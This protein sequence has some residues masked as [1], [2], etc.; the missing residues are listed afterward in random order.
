MTSPIGKVIKS[1]EL[2]GLIG[3]GGFGAV[4][5]AR[6]AVVEREVAIKIIWPAFANH[7]NFI[8][9]FEAEAQIVAGLEHPYI[10]PLY[11]Y[12]R[13]PDGAYIVMRLLRGGHLRQ[14]I[15]ETA[16][17]TLPDILRVV[18]Q[19]AAALA[20]AH[21]Y[22]VVHRDI[23]PENILLDEDKNTY[24]ADFGI[25]QIISNATAD[26]DVMASMGSP[27]YA[28]PEQIAGGITS[29][30]SD[31]YSLGII[32]YEMLCSEH[33]FPY[34]DELS[35]T[36][37]VQLR[38]TEPV[39]S[40]L[41]Q[42]PDL[43]PAVNNVIQRATALDARKRYP[44]ALSFYQ[45]LQQAFS[46]HRRTHSTMAPIISDDDILPN[47]YKGLRAFQET[48]AQNFF[49]REALV[50]RM[51]NR[52]KESHADYHRFLTV[53]GPSGSGKSSVV[54]AG[55]LPAMRQG[56]MENSEN[57]FYDDFVPGP[58]PFRELENT[59]ISLATDPP[60]NLL[61]QLRDDPTALSRIIPRLLP[62]P[63]SELFLV[64]DQFEEIFTLGEQEE[65]VNRF[66]D[67]LYYAVTAPDSR[68]RL[69][70]TIRADFYDRPL[71]Q[72]RLS[73]M[74]R[75]RT[76]VVVPLS[77][78][79]L[80]KVIV[81]PA[82]RAGVRIDSGLVAAIIAEIKEQPGALPLLQY[83]LS[84]LFEHRRDNVIT[85]E[86]YRDL[87]G[88]RGSLARRADQLYKEM[89]DDERE[90]V[91]QLFLRLITLGEGTE[92]TRRRAL[93][94][95]ITTLRDNDPS[96]DDTAIMRRVVDKLGAVRLITFD[97]DPVTRS[98]TVEV[99][100]EAI[101]R[102]WQR[103]RDWLDESRNDVRM[104]RTLSGLANE[105]HEAQQDVSFLMRGIR[106]DS[107]QKWAQETRLALTDQEKAYLLNS[108]EER[109][110]RIEEEKRR[111]Q[112][113][114]QL[115][116]QAL[117]RLRYLVAVLAVAMLGALLLSGFA[118]NESNRASESARQAEVALETS[119]ASALI[120]SSLALEA[121]ARR[122][123]SEKDGDLAVVLA[124]Q[125]N[126]IDNPPQQ[127]VT[128]LSEVALSRGTR[129]RIVAHEA[130]V[131]AVDISPDGT[132][133]VSTSTDATVK[134]RDMA[135]GELLHSMSGHGGDVEA[136]AFSPDGQTVLSAA[137]DFL[138][139]LWDANTGE[140][141][142]RFIGHSLPVRSVSFHPDGTQAVTAASDSLLILWDVNTGEEIRRYAGHDGSV[143]VA[144]FS[145][146]GR[147]ILSGARDGGLFLWDAESGTVLHRMIGH[148]TTVTDVTFSPD[149]QRAVSGSGDGKIL[150]WDTATG[151]LIR[152]FVGI[153]D[154]VRSVL[155][156]PDGDLVYSSDINGSIHVWDTLSGLEIDRLEGHSDTVMNLAISQDGRV[157]ASGSKD[158]TIRLWNI[159]NPAVFQTF[160][161]HDNRV[162]KLILTGSETLYSGSA[163]GSLRQWN[164]ADN[165][166]R[167][168]FQSEDSPV[169]S[170]SINPERT[171]IALGTRGGIFRIIDLATGADMVIQE[172]HDESVLALAYLSD[173]RLL[174]A[175]ESGNIFL[176]NAD[177]TEII[178][179]FEG[180]DNAIYSIAVHP[181]E[182]L[183]ASGGRDNQAI[184]WDIETGEPLHVL[185]NHTSSI[186]TVA[187]S[188]DGSLLATGSRDTLVILWDVATGAEVSPLFEDNGVVWSVAF[189]HNGDELLVG[190]GDGE[191][192]LWDVERADIFQ[193]FAVDEDTAIFS[194]AASPSGDFAATG[195]ENGEVLLW[196]TFDASELIEWTR[197][198]RYVRELDCYEHEQYRIEPFCS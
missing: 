19:M 28:A 44:D 84:E 2:Q 23:K 96:S 91:R 13:D 102:E 139:I 195:L 138:A 25:A 48:D 47:P 37:M 68:L 124:L 18:N 74:V 146:D 172:A 40:I 116:R 104:Q 31:I 177:T 134:I 123:L 119:D 61:Q 137:T 189:N 191:F 125:A 120:S 41:K 103:L 128:T 133:L 99:A 155:F 35:M 58:Q 66:L 10:V 166:S 53:V 192:L 198:N 109:D 183:L 160:E 168:V 126:A 42:R 127:S 194:I 52:L 86:V 89:D 11:D 136:V 38:T 98:P 56:I 132:R 12:W 75:E 79:E 57:W 151:Q 97:R 80:E 188:P 130:W 131:T 157:L 70:I 51:V 4:Y 24:L 159:D 16:T 154:E 76:E 181:D 71:L 1:Y 60:E 190:T 50:Q 115:E 107:Y 171:R 148:N 78:A 43:P 149:G 17:W 7:P 175:D 118:F 161:A 112:R 176:W 77:P 32:L 174:S 150:L 110:R 21:R 67:S 59:L 108:I 95:E 122:A 129:S 153:Q 27:A 145:P 92:D 185:S 186:Y 26:D 101:I 63:D 170:M 142:R 82:R 83:T 49:G 143:L 158:T 72:P 147:T 184:I 39:P 180:H 3:T 30:Q 117:Q 87:G 165:T 62:D 88:V 173:G 9:R 20:L 64:I 140:E 141:I 196:H 22:G 162:A 69:V 197:Q 182:T 114:E 111:Q 100:H 193:R 8:R 90:S 5:R 33:P 73:D 113:E 135:S 36:G 106:L 29:S 121:S 46:Q 94:E 105:W 55:L 144:K 65:D 81:E 167:L 15:D 178:R 54:K 164:L 163:D 93:M 179:R 34:L 169:L 187:F 45:D 156:S 6:Q 14:R 85:P 152:E